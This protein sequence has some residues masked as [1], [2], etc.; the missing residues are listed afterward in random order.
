[1]RCIDTMLA[2]HKVHGSR[3]FVDALLTGGHDPEHYL[4][5]VESLL[6]ALRA[7]R[8]L[9][10]PS[11]A[12]FGYN[13]LKVL[14][15]VIEAQTVKPDEEKVEAIRRLTPPVHLKHVRA[16]LGLVGFYRRFIPNFA[17][18]AKPM[19]NLTKGN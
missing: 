17:R 16:F 1:M 14:G 13:R 9:I 7:D 15:H 10:S 2:R 3:G 8:W 18:L 6:G 5:K 11:K 19:I 12:R 4:D